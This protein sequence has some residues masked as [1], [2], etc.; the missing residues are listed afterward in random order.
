MRYPVILQRESDG[1][2][3]ATVPGLSGCISQGDSRAEVKNTKEPLVKPWK[4]FLLLLAA[5]LLALGLY[6]VRLMCADLAPRPSLLSRKSQGSHRA[7]LVRPAQGPPRSKPV[8]A[9]SCG[10]RHHPTF[11]VVLHSG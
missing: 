2:Y 3:V 10:K 9:D 1:G 6:G 7:Q 11:L 5:E 4:I 8:E